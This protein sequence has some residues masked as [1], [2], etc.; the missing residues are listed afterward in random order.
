MEN[1]RAYAQI[2]LPK[3]ACKASFLLQK[4]NYLEYFQVF[5]V[6]RPQYPN[7]PMALRPW[8]AKP[9]RRAAFEGVPG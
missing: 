7:F 8:Q 6:V 2:L 5:I 4:V 3:S 1:N 9:F